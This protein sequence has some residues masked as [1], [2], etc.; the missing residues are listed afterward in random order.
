MGQKL[1]SSSSP[2]SNTPLRVK[3]MTDT[4]GFKRETTSHGD[5]SNAAAIR[6]SNTRIVSKG[7]RNTGR[8]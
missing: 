4:K 1:E 8:K 2:Q 7:S 5:T 6:G 3:D